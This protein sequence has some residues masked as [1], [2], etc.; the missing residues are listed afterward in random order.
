MEDDERELV[1]RLLERDRAAGELFERR[2]RD[3]LYR[4]AVAFLGYQD[5][6]AEDVI[7]ETFLAALRGLE[8]FEFR[9]S[10]YTWLNQICVR[11]CFRRLRGRRRLVLSV[12]ADLAEALE[13]PA[14]EED[15]PLRL[16][17]EEQRRWLE[18]ALASLGAECREIL[19]LRDVEGKSYADI[20]KTLRL[21]VGTVMSRLAR[22]RGK[23]KKL[24][25]RHA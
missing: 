5:P 20:S 19:R 13:I 25:R 15:A 22:C 24:A 18:R 11:L 2:Y 10:L 4:V 23:L 8:G 1:R 17:R 14:P 21:A 3:R 7:Q 6:E 9:S 16:E 12:G